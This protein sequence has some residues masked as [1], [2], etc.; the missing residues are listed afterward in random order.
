MKQK[1]LLINNIKQI[2]SELKTFE[3][4]KI[5]SNVILNSEKNKFIK[6]VKSGAF[7]EMLSEIENREKIKKKE[8]LLDKVFKLF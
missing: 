1:K 5:E 6:E 3:E 2:E 4:E 7:D 8:S